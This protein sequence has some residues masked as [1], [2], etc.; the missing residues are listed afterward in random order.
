[1]ASHAPLPAPRA[2]DRRNGLDH[3]RRL[4]LLA[5]AQLAAGRADLSRRD[6]AMRRWNQHNRRFS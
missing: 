5:R 4:F 3:S 2:D 1:M 6:A